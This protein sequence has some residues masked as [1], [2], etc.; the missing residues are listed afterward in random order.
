MLLSMEAN[1]NTYWGAGIH[2]DIINASVIALISSVNRL[3]Q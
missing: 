1:G 3:D 2:E